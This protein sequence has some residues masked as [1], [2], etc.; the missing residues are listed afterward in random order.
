[1]S[2]L[3]SKINDYLNSISA[4]NDALIIEMEKFAEQNNIPILQK[5]SIRFLECLICAIKPKSVLEIGTAIGYT[6][7][8]IAKLLESDAKIYSIEKSKGNIN[9]ADEFIA[10]SKQG[11]KIEILSGEAKNILPSI[12]KYFDL[13]FLDA[14]K[15]DYRK[16]FDFSF[17]LLREDGIYIVD[18]LLWSGYVSAGKIPEKKLTA[19]KFIKDFNKHFLSIEGLNSTILPIGDGIGFGVKI[20]T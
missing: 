18:N 2:T 11:N 1:M 4:A 3:N 12:N 6:T 7:I 17:P 19:T 14:D 13:I 9:L 20:K 16:L 15:Q 10:R 5:N 8:R